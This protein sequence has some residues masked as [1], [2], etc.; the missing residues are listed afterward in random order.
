MSIFSG[1]KS[2]F[3]KETKAEPLAKEY[4]PDASATSPKTIL[5]PKPGQGGREQGQ[6]QDYDERTASRVEGAKGS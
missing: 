2:L 5:K 6:R 1:L 3:K 4:P